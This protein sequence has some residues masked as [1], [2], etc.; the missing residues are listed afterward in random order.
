VIGFNVTDDQC[1]WMKAGIVNFHLCDNAFDCYTCPFDIGMRKA[2]HHT[3]KAGKERDKKA[4]SSSL[5]QRYIAEGETTLCRHA[6]TGRINAQ[7]VCTRNYECHH[8]EY[9]QWLDEYDTRA[10]ATK[11]DLKVASGYR[12][13]D[14]YYYHKGHTWARFDHGG[15]VRIGFDDFL[16]RLFGNMN[17]INMPRTGENLKQ[18]REGLSFRRDNDH[19]ANV[20]SPVTGTV[21]AV[22]HTAMKHPEI[23]HAEPYRE[24]WLCIV[25]PRMPKMNI[26]N[27]AYGSDI[28]KWIELES[29]KLLGLMGPEYEKLAALG[30]KPIADVY[31][32]YPELGWDVLVNNF[33]RA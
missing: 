31:G 3:A 17:T 18:N 1:I 22:N 9:D 21:L 2:M 28:Y 14:G 27:L 32:N 16:V 4:W 8:C 5:N 13:A 26:K 20:L 29:Q 33:L 15:F 7:K 6:L 23:V 12:I 25:Q 11:T 10:P 24:G 30:G 19:R